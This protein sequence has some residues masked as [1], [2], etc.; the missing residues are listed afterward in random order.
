MSRIPQC[1][2]NLVNG[3]GERRGER[4]LVNKEV[5]GGER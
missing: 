5:N 2:I 3:R 4:S 1:S